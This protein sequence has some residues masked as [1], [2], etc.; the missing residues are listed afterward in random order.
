MLHIQDLAMRYPTDHADHADQG[1]MGTVAVFENVTLRARPGEFI[2]IIGESGVGKSTLLNLI[3]GLDTA[4]AGTVTVGEQNITTM[5]ARDAALFRRSNVGFVF[6]AFH[7]L[8]HLTVAQNVGV[9][10]LLQGREDTVKVQ[11]MLDAVGLGKLGARLPQTLSGGQLQRVAIARAMVHQPALILADE[12]TGNLDPSTG[13]AV[14]DVFAQQVREHGA[15]TLLVTHS[16]AAAA[17]ADR[18]LRLTSSGLINA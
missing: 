18:V 12:P 14:L 13:L 11:A 15:L 5:N 4:S 10:L 9:P 6:Q 16:V 8:P 1:D 3:A 2:A 17:R 7:V